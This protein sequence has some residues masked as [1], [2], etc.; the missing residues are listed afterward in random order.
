[1]PSS[2]TATLDVSD[3]RQTLW[4]NE[5]EQL[6]QHLLAKSKDK[7]LKEIDRAKNEQTYWYFKLAFTTGMRLKEINTLKW[8]QVIAPVH[9]TDLSKKIKR[10]IYLP[11]T[12]TARKRTITS[13]VAYIFNALQKLYES[14]G[15]EIDRTSDTRVF[16]KLY[17]HRIDQ[18]SWVTD[19]AMVDRLDKA[20]KETGLFQKRAGTP[21]RRITPNSSRHYVAT[22]QSQ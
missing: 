17:T 12:K 9:E 2:A 3:E 21:P 5:W 11:Q 18:E 16:F 19:K 20:M 13:E 8:N 4:E 22:P 15:A 10:S 14:R 6:Q 7:K 1:M